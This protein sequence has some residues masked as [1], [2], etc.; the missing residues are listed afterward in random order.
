MTMRMF[1]VKNKAW[2]VVNLST[3]KMLLILHGT[4]IGFTRS[5]VNPRPSMRETSCFYFLSQY[6]YSEETLSKFRGWSSRRGAVVNE[7]D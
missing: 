6:P 3:S 4:V 2:C 1:L 5:G 7:P